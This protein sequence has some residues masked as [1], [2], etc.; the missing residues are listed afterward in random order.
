MKNPPHP[1]ELVGDSLEELGWSVAE[2]AEAM[3]VSRQQLHNVISG[4]SAISAEMAIRLEKAIG[5]SA[6]TWLRMQV[7]YDL[8]Q[9]EASLGP[10]KIR[11]LKKVESLT[12]E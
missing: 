5:S 1:G 8:A 10:I 9:A 4:R 11:R 6:A 7:A 3:G 2:A 12:T